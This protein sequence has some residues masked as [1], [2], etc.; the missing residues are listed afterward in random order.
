MEFMARLSALVPP[1]RFPR[2]HNDLGNRIFSS[3]GAERVFDPETFG[4]RDRIAMDHG[5]ETP[6]VRDE[7]VAGRV[8][9]VVRDVLDEPSPQRL[10]GHEVGAGVG[11]RF[12]RDA[13][14]HGGPRHQPRAM[15]RRAVPDHADRARR[16]LLSQ[17][18]GFADKRGWPPVRWKLSALGL[19][20][21]SAWTHAITDS[22]LRSVST[23]TG[24]ALLPLAIS[25]NASNRSRVGR[26]IGGIS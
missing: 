3:S 1:P 26:L 16:K 17:P 21:L 7:F 2:N 11:Q 6:N 4:E 8:A 19:C 23:A 22:S 20:S 15:V 10:G 12:Q 5:L 24:V 25:Y 9:A 13:D 18:L 14:T